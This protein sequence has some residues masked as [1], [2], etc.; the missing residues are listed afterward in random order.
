MSA[1]QAQYCSPEVRRAIWAAIEDKPFTLD[2]L[3]LLSGIPADDT[4]KYVALLIENGYVGIRGLRRAASGE[5]LPVFRQLVRNG[6][7]PPFLDRIDGD[8]IDPC[9]L[10]VEFQAKRLDLPTMSARLRVAAERLG[11]PFSRQGLFAAVF[12]GISPLPQAIVRFG[13][14]WNCLHTAGEIKT[15]S[16]GEYAFVINPVTERI[17][18]FLRDNQGVAHKSRDVAQALGLDI[19][20]GALMRSAM[21]LLS[22]EGY[23]VAIRASSAGK[24]RTYLVERGNNGDSN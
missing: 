12:G 14:S 13:H 4:L 3:E 15:L 18:G 24:K 9:A 6:S 19:I 21:D 5:A 16:P 20:R 11:G 2:N 17:R 22:A 10:P 8:L 7:E 23:S 1:E